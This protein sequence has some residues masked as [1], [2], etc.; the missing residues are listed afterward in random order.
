M[1]IIRQHMSLTHK[2]GLLCRM[3]A[4]QLCIIQVPYIMKLS[5]NRAMWY[6][7]S[8]RNWEIFSF[9]PSFFL[10]RQFKGIHVGKKQASV[11]PHTTFAFKTPCT[12]LYFKLLTGLFCLRVFLYYYYYYYFPNSTLFAEN[13]KLKDFA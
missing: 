11:L 9:P 8:W 12:V 13:S 1:H 6:V 10:S 5:C 4:S 2:E 7:K 3:S